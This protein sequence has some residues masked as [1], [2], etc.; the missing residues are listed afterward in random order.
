MKGGRVMVIHTCY[1]VDIK[2]QLAVSVDKKTQELQIHRSYRVDDRL[3]KNTADLC[4]E[5]LKFCVSAF[6]EEWETLG[7]QSG[8]SRKRTGDVL[9]HSTKDNTAKYPE[10][11]IRFAGMPSYTRR[12]I[13]SKAL[14]IVSSYQSNLKNWLALSPADRGN[15]PV[16]GIPERYE[17]TFYDQERKMSSLDKGQIGLKLYNG[18][19]WE[20]YY[21]QIAGSDASYLSSLCK[22]RKLLSPVVEKVRGKYRIRFCFEEKQELV[23]AE[24][25]LAYSVLAVD[26]GINAA[27]S[28]CVM[29]ADGTVHAKGVIH[30]ACEED[31]L[32]HLINRK[33]KYQRAG[34]K[35]QCVYRWVRDANLRLS[36]E[37]AKAIMNVAVLYS[38]D[39]I[40]FEHLDRNKKLHGGKYRERIH[41]WRK[42]DV[43]ERVELQAHRHGMRIS[44]VCAWGTS[45]LA[46]DGSG[47]VD[48]HSFFQEKGDKKIYNYSI[49]TF[50]NKKVYNCDLSAAQNI[51]ARFFLR[52]YAKL[53]VQ[54]LPA[55]PQRTLSTLRLLIKDGLKTVSAA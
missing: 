8:K 48:R 18:T 10:F 28:W 3:M 55:T 34:K 4:L 14:G 29:T 27:A 32:N 25:R 26:L 24:D 41:L 1:V 44:R 39:C 35:S 30:L 46:F 53:G 7:N 52:E 5:A 20:W 40:V 49:C 16:L 31:R 19:S 22:T 33:R 23:Q 54:G 45:K 38:V 50:A 21:F 42:N 15:P 36:I 47:C 51:G 2:R 13:V 12:T 17:L 11:D 43:Q 9:V 37:T 6:Q